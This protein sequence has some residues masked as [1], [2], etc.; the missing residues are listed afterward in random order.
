MLYRLEQYTPDT[1]PAG[2]FFVADN[3]TVVGRVTLGEDVGI[4]FNAVVRGDVEDLHIGARTNIQDGCVLHADAGYQLDIGVGVTVG[5][6]AMLHGCT[7]GANSLIGIKAVV[8]NG[9]RIGRNCI[10]G[11]NALIAEGKHIPDNSLV[12]GSPG[13]VKR[14]VTAE[15]IEHLQWSSDHYVENFKYFQRSCEALR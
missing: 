15:E 10:I 13:R 5:H 2:R 11:A 14:E 1:P 8:L 7:I 4:W 9:A 3:A 12:L 6:Q